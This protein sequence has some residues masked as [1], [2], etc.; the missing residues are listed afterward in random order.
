MRLRCLLPSLLLTTVVLGCSSG[1]VDD[2]PA[3]AASALSGTCDE[4]KL[5]PT[6]TTQTD[7]A[8]R[9]VST[10]VSIEASGCITSANGAALV[11]RIASILS[12]DAKLKALAKGNGNPD[13]VFKAFKATAPVGTLDSSAGQSR[14]ADVTFNN[15]VAPSTTLALTLRKRAAELDFALTN[16]ATVG[17]FGIHAVDPG[18]L[19]MRLTARPTANGV[20]IE[21]TTKIVVRAGFESH[22]EKI[23]QLPSLII[24]WVKDEIASSP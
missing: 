18:G 3:G 1:A 4:V 6:R 13:L 5:A 8:G 7:G 21:G 12:N 19:D 24:Q 9:L 22:L 15:R 23:D 11:D 20:V 17:R 10:T 2:D 14:S 16:T